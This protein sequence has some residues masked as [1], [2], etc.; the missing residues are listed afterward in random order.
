M[1]RLPIP[2]LALSLTL[3]SACAEESTNVS[4]T[5]GSQAISEAAP[6]PPQR[7]RSIVEVQE[8]FDRNKATFISI[9]NQANRADSRISVGEIR[10]RITIAPDGTVSECSVVSSTYDNPEFEQKIANAVRQLH[11]RAKDEPPFTI[12]SY[13][14]TFHPM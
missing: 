3:L 4:G 1:R 13:P 6:S 12:E 5:T 11:F 9:F 2:V 10:L 8:N 14:I 7:P